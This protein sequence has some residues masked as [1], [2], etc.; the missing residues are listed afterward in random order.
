MTGPSLPDAAVGLGTRIGRY[1]SIVS[2]LPALFLTA[3]TFA[4]VASGAWSGA[5]NLKRMVDGLT[6]VKLGDVAWLAMSTVI[7]ALFLHPLQLA[8]TRLFEGYWGSSRL[9]TSLLRHRITH[10]RKRVARINRRRDRLEQRRDR[11]LAKVLTARYLREL[12]DDP[13]TAD[14]PAGWDDARLQDELEGVVPSRRAHAASGAHAALASIPHLLARYPEP[15]RMMPTRLGN[16]LR[17]AEDSIGRQFAL[18]AIRTTPYVALVAPESHL[19]YLQDTRQQMDTSVRLCVV[20]L[21]ATAETFGFLLTDGWWL[22]V[23]LGP[24]SLAYIAYRASVAAAEEYMGIVRTVLDLNRFKLYESLHLKPPRNT[25]EERRNNAK[26]MDLLG[27]DDEVSLRY[28][29]PAAGTPST[30]T[31]PPTPPGTP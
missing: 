4:L 12:A 15:G 1:F 26:L 7:L 5:P 28:K 13:S 21:L 20:A 29:H 30:G 10:Y 2:L 18:D 22:L 23:T 31:V 19:G 25:R 11:V 3:W 16:A 8:M 6:T 9:A 14:D 24:Y 27:G 17:S